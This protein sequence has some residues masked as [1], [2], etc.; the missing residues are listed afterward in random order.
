MTEIKEQIDFVKTCGFV[1]A[2]FSWVTFVRGKFNW[3]NFF[4]DVMKKWLRIP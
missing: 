2:A 3:G 4:F 1:L